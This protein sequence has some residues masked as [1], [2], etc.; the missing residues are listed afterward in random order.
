MKIAMLGVHHPLGNDG[1][2]RDNKHTLPRWDIRCALVLYIHLNNNRGYEARVYLTVFR[3]T[4][5]GVLNLLM[6]SS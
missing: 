2:I 6:I 3:Y 1:L 5:L 4:G